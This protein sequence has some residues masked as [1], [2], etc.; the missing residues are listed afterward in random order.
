[1]A[2]EPRAPVPRSSG[3]SWRAR[4]ASLQRKL[5]M[6]TPTTQ[7]LPAYA[8]GSPAGLAK[9]ARP[10]GPLS[11]RTSP[12]PRF[13]HES[14]NLIEAHSPHGPIILR[15]PTSESAMRASARRWRSIC[16]TALVAVLLSGCATRPVRVPCGDL[17][18]AA[19]A[20]DACAAEA[21]NAGTASATPRPE[22][23]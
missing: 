15:E 7:P 5:G 13:P 6:V 14:H 9:E 8:G 3:I 20:T 2:L 18:P 1:M 17:P 22:P 16:G 11:L 10:A 23:P 12:N 4:R 21:L 19:G